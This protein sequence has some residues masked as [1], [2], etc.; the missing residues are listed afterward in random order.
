MSTHEPGFQSF[1]RFL[2]HFVL[3][4]LATNSIRVNKAMLNQTG[5]IPLS[6]VFLK[7]LLS[8]YFNRRQI[9]STLQM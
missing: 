9:M 5:A 6:H 2:H 1:F 7:I 8:R 3:A 4:K